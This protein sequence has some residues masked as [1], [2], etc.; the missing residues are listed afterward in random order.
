MRKPQTIKYAAFVYLRE[1]LDQRDALGGWVF[2]PTGGEHN[3]DVLWFS[4]EFFTPSTI[5]THA[6]TK[7]MDGKLI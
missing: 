3:G 1:A 7:G 5:F 4:A 2:V 6:L